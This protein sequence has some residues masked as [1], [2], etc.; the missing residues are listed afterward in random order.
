MKNPISHSILYI[1]LQVL[2][3]WVDGVLGIGF[4]VMAVLIFSLDKKR[5]MSSLFRQG[6]LIVGVEILID[7]FCGNAEVIFETGFW[8]FEEM[9]RVVLSWSWMLGLIIIFCFFQKGRTL[10][11]SNWLIDEFFLA[12]AISPR[13]CLAFFNFFS[14]WNSVNT[15]SVYY[16]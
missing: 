3:I 5:N 10:Q 16:K 6:V 11:I 8:F 1:L 9:R 12:A 13:L 2:G 14:K 7:L 15:L 4:E